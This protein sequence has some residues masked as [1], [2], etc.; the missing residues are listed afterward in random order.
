M[1]VY[2][3]MCR[4]TQ[5]GG[6]PVL[7]T[8]SGIH[9]PW[10]FVLWQVCTE[11]LCCGEVYRGVCRWVCTEGCIQRG[12]VQRGYVQRGIYIGVCTESRYV[13]KGGYVQRVYTYGELYMQRGVVYLQG[14]GYL[15]RG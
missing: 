2:E 12:Y 9:G 13:Q 1:K 6:N 15:Q 8:L 4:D 7:L 10:A 14:V 3:Q 11:G 5:G